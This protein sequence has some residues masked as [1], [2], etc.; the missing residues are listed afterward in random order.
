M[1][2]LAYGVEPYYS[3][4]IVKR[5]YI[6]LKTSSLG[7]CVL[8]IIP[9]Y[10]IGVAMSQAV[11]YDVHVH[12]RL[13]YIETLDYLIIVS[14]YYIVFLVKCICFQ[15]YYVVLC[16]FHVPYKCMFM[17]CWFTTGYGF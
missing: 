13:G 4:L 5:Y 9:C 7:F 6:E 15:L 12:T 16:Y 3:C 11:I 14:E 10:L 1:Q 17:L 2:L 8:V